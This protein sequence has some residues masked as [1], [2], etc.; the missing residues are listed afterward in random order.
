MNA[1]YQLKEIDL[2]NLNQ[3]NECEEKKFK[4]KMNMKS[5]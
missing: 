3:K 2:K 5:K 1:Q 4:F